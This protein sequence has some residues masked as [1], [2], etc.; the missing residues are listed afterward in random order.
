MVLSSACQKIEKVVLADRYCDSVIKNLHTYRNVILDKQPLGT[1]GG[2]LDGYFAADSVVMITH[3]IAHVSVYQEN[4]FFKSGMLVMVKQSRVKE[5][6]FF[7]MTNIISLTTNFF[8][9]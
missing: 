1:W 9:T 7:L 8:P 5:R 2:F 6:S 4:Y 3:V